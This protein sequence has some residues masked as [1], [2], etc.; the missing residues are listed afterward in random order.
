MAGTGAAASAITNLAPDPSLPGP[1][2]YVP[3]AGAA[4]RLLGFAGAVSDALDAPI[5][6]GLGKIGLGSLITHAPGQ[7]AEIANKHAEDTNEQIYKEL[8]G[9]TVDPSQPGEQMA[10]SIGTGLGMMAPIAPASGAPGFLKWLMPPVEHAPINVPVGGA[11]GASS[12]AMQQ[13]LNDIDKAAAAQP[14]PAAQ[15][16]A[17]D[18]PVQVAQNVPP[19]TATDAPTLPKF[20]DFV[21]Q[22]SQSQPASFVDYL[23]KGNTTLPA[24]DFMELGA[25]QH[26]VARDLF[27]FAS[28]LLGIGAAAFT[29][30]I[31]AMATDAARTARFNDP[32]YAAQ[33]QAYNDSVI[34]RG[35]AEISDPAA[36]TRAPLVE[37]A[38]PV[39]GANKIHQAA[40][41][42]NTQMLNSNAQM[43]DAIRMSAEPS[44][45]ER[46]AHM[47][48]NTNDD[49]AA[50]IKLDNFIETG[51]DPVSGVQI[52][53]PGDLFWKIGKLKQQGNGRFEL[54]DDGKAAR[55]EL[56]N[57]A[58]N[59]ADYTG[60]GPAP[61]DQVRHNFKNQ[62]DDEL[63][64]ISARSLADPFINDINEHFKAVTNGL[65]DIGTARDFF[66]ADE[67]ARLKA[68]HP[69]YVPE[70][71]SDGALLHPFGS[72]D[73]S[74]F[75]GVDQKNSNAHVNLAQHIDQLYGQFA[76]NDMNRALWQS[77]TD[78]QRQFPNS[79]QFMYEVQPPVGANTPNYYSGV[80]GAAREPIVRIRTASGPKYVR[81]DSPDHFRAMTANSSMKQKIMSS[82]ITVPRRIYQRGT[83]GVL[84]GLAGKLYA[85]V[86]PTYTAFT[87]PVNAPRKMYG[88]MIDRA[89]QRTT[90]YT[91]GAARG[92]DMIPNLVGGVPYS[93]ARGVGDRW[94]N[95][96]ADWTRKEATNPINRILRSHLTDPVVD[97]MSQSARDFYI[98]SRTNKIREMGIGGLGQPI[99][100]DLPALQTEGNN[101]ARLHGAR[102]AP[103]AFF[104]GKWLGM[105]P[106]FIKLN[107]AIQEAFVNIGDAGNDYFA[108]LNYDNPNVSKETLA[109][110]TRALTGNPSTSG[111]N[112]VMQGASAAIPYFNIGVQGISRF[113]R[114]FGERPIS[115]PMSMAVGLGS[116]ALLS[117]MTHMRSQAH[118]NYLQNEVPLQQRAGALILATSD[119]PHKPTIITLPQELRVPYAYALDLVSKALNVVAMHHEPEIATRVMNMLKDFFYGH[120]TNSTQEAAI[121]GAVDALGIPNL[122]P[123]MGQIDYNKLAHGNSIVESYKSPMQSK[124]LNLPNQVADGLLDD[125]EG[126][127]WSNI[128]T[129]LFGGMG[130]AFDS[131][132][133]VS[134][135]KEQTGSWVQA[136]GMAGHDWLQGM[137]DKNPQFNVLW[138]NPVRMSLQPPIVE[139]TQRQLDALDKIGG[140][141]PA[142]SAEGFTGRNRYAQPVPMTTTE[143]IPTDP[144]MLRMYSLAE[145]YKQRVAE[146]RQEISQIRAQMGAVQNQ[147][148]NPQ[149]KRAWM[150]ERTRDVTDKYRFIDSTLADLN[151]GLSTLAG[152]PL[153]IEEFS[154]ADMT[155]GVDQF[156]QTSQAPAVPNP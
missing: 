104:D 122:P 21:D 101:T 148:M 69:D 13:G 119:D 55:D 92:L 153:R 72:R 117:V 145:A 34:R 49:G 144:T 3:F 37:A 11:L 73:P 81:V 71:D 124:E 53:S 43:M 129:S 12:E 123:F 83:T 74:S 50:A 108:R 14:I 47:Y 29:H 32:T 94:I 39:T 75:T 106:F 67:G 59:R 156:K 134:R 24:P 80:S 51:H 9:P 23:Q 45:A 6:Y 66:T 52:P 28:V 125:K 109:Y 38:S 114:S 89:V 107:N 91:S 142:E 78:T 105:K 17:P 132:N 139:K 30:R 19:G 35:G 31:G 131:A 85:V 5:N 36:P 118:L 20:S 44:T 57:R 97:S 68:R 141:R 143:K 41:Y 27:T 58:N 146:Q 140:S 135:Y 115:A 22:Q 26:S 133:S 100:S 48:G 136:L 93:Y 155:R 84:A 8:G 152:R 40:N 112:T 151:Q 116:L 102:A 82:M 95:R 111:A 103:D 138:E 46:L 61:D 15:P 1:L 110:E 126:K 86:N 90:G 16:V 113:A 7:T 96:F 18:Q 54:W 62:S 60:T 10:K 56:D 120:V 70:V 63:R 149:D 147:G 77:Q 137:H 127:V 4:E 121:H 79:A 42:A 64:A 2:G 98:Q 76:K 150:N 25:G 87:M 128:L 65:V 33:A 99:R 88:G 130:A 154:R